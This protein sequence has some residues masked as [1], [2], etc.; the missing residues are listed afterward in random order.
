M[1]K[2]PPKSVSDP[3]GADRIVGTGPMHDLVRRHDW[4]AT[5]LGPLENWSEA[6]ITIVN[7]TLSAPLP[8]TL[9]WGP[10]YI[11]F[12]NE[13]AIHSIGA[14]HPWALGAPYREVFA[15]A[16]DFVGPEM[17]DCYLR[18][19]PVVHENVLTPV[20]RAGTIED[21]YWTY[22]RVPVHDGGRIAGV[23]IPHRNTTAA[24]LA[25]R[26]RDTFAMRMNQFL[27]VTKDAVV[28][29][30]R[31][32]CISYLNDTAQRMYGGG[33]S[34]VGKKLWESFPEASYEGSP[35]V[36]HYT[37]A[38]DRGEPGYFETHHAAPWNLWLEVEV[39][40]TAEGFVTFSRDT[41]EKRRALAV[42]MQNEKLAAVGRL[43]SSIAHEI[44]NP[45]ESVT[46]LL[47]IARKTS[48]PEE[49]ASLLDLADAE[50]RR[51]AVITN[52]TLR[53]HRQASSPQEVTC[54]ALFSTV[55]T[56]FEGKLRNSGIQVEKR[57][58]AAKAIRIF[59]G[60]IRQVLNNLIGNAIDSMPHGGRLIVRSRETT[61]WSTGD[62]GLVLTIAD[63]GTGIPPEVQDRVFEAFFTTKGISG[64]G[65]GLWIS[66][67][68][69]ARH[70]GELRLRS[71]QREGHRGTVATLFLPFNAVPTT[72]T[73]A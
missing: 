52:Q 60:D 63:T 40:P 21:H 13:A 24:V 64:S 1:P 50:L 8:V 47:Y 14:K 11:T 25:F 69:V 48:D 34:L 16:W 27:S 30:D 7:H 12:Y 20:N 68:I 71:S 15:E 56:M 36:E 28:G 2:A 35:Y 73:P 44:N 17:E 46:N 72:S 42:L 51:V 3:A 31:N 37:R 26:Q 23:L 6:Q 5:P 45:L 38:M 65:L 49:V 59:E 22:S 66:R 29:V 43:A 33:R 54:L 57:K 62:K 53:F 10:E 58:R 70:G 39:Y 9:T 4:A 67:D 32:W 55:L 19:K 61:R 18:G 41:S